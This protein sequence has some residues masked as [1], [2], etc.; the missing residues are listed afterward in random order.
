MSNSE[1]T[2]TRYQDL[3]DEQDQAD[4]HEEFPDDRRDASDSTSDD[5]R[6]I[7]QEILK[8]RKMLFFE[9]SADELKQVVPINRKKSKR[10]RGD[11]TRTMN[12]TR[13]N[14]KHLE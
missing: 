6:Q 14:S 2:E 1:A 11:R 7:Q 3:V 4:G 8:R 12:K 9:I 13:M 5:E 10:T